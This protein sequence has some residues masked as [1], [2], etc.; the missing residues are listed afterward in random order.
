M[1]IFNF[2]LICT[3]VAFILFDFNLM[4]CMSGEAASGTVDLE[5]CMPAERDSHDI[6]PV[7]V[8]GGK[9]SESVGVVVDL[10]KE[11]FNTYRLRQYYNSLKQQCHT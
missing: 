6:S 11:K 3:V 1:R 7:R 10:G 5:A 2:A 9:K 8:T 4:Y